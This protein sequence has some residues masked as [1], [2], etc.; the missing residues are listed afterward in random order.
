MY[1]T[2]SFLYILFSS[3]PVLCSVLFPTLL[4]ITLLISKHSISLCELE[5]ISERKREIYL[6]MYT[7]LEF[8]LS[9]TQLIHTKPACKVKRLWHHVQAIQISKRL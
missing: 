6:L 1:F 8:G 3:N 2:P 4:E 7:I 9:L 5:R